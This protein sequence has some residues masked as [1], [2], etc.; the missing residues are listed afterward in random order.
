MKKFNVKM[1]MIAFVAVFLSFESAVSDVFVKYEVVDGDSLRSGKTEIRLVDID[2][3]EFFQ[4]CYDENDEY[5][6]CGKIAAKVLRKYIEGGVK[7]RGNS[8]DVYSR[9]LL[10]CFDKTKESINK[11]MVSEGWAI[12]YGNRFENE[13]NDAKHKKKGIWKGRFMR[14]ELYR[15]L[16]NKKKNFDK[17]KKR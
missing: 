6:D 17:F 16:H 4:K 8:K 5:Y 2:A 7:C 3:P 11:K 14:P 10:E 15:A 9:Y 1:L 12:S 13:E